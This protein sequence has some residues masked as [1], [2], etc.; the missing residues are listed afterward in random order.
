ME[1]SKACTCEG[2][3]SKEVGG[4]GIFI[5][6]RAD[7]ARYVETYR[8]IQLRDKVTSRGV[9]QRFPCMNFGESKGR[10]FDSVI[11]IPTEPMLAWIRNADEKLAPQTR[12]KFYVALTRARRN[13]ALVADW[14]DGYI[15]LGCSL[16]P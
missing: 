14:S 9:D 5:V 12:A 7:Y 3:H 1:P 11:I 6:K 15:P 16:F 8:P 10:G 4:S 2:C 13:V